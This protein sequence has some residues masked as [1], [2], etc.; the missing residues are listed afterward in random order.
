MIDFRQFEAFEGEKP[1]RLLDQH[2]D[3]KHLAMQVKT[4]DVFLSAIWCADTKRVVCFRADADAH[5]LAWLH[6]GTQMAVL[7]NPILSKD[8]LFVTYSWPQCDLL[9]QCSLRF[10]MGYLFDLVISP[11][12][13]FAVCQWT[14]QCEFGF[15][16][17]M[18]AEHRIVHLAQQGYMN[19]TT[20]YTT[21]PVFHPDGRFW[22]CCAQTNTSWWADENTLEK[23][24]QPGKG[25]QREIGSILV[26]ESAHL[27]GEIPLL[28]TVPAG[29]LPPGIG[30]LEGVS[31][32]PVDIADPVFLDGH[33]IMI[34]LPLGG[35]Q[36]HDVSPFWNEYLS[37]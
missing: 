17:V 28:I 33:H 12:N 30:T 35:T 25:G 29:Y 7:Q 10:P 26:F 37:R 19:Q 1:F 18:L 15:E 36:I 16:F 3:G 20:I 4:A 13:D 31:D 32:E 22:V 21:R 23:Y 5:A 6:Q 27:L 9:Q 2:P 8:F 11:T 24:D 14:D 34:R